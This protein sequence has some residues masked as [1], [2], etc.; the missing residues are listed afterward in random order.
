MQMLLVASMLSAQTKLSV[1]VEGIKEE[2]GQVMVAVF[3]SLNF[4]KKPVAADMSKIEGDTLTFVFDRLEAGD[5]AVSV[6]L[7]ANL[8]Y[9]LDRDEHG[10]PVEKWGFSN[11]FLPSKGKPTFDDCKFAIHPDKGTAQRIKLVKSTDY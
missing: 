1:T 2:K 6:F 8:N 11:N 3:D 10:I 7:D 9:M 4:F 5:Y